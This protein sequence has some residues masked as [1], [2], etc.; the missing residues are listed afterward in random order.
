MGNRGVG[1]GGV[2]GGGA[3]CVVVVAT[4]VWGGLGGSFSEMR[5]HTSY[6]KS[7]SV[8]SM[9]LATANVEESSCTVKRRYERSLLKFAEDK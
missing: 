7:R 6:R 4:G 8:N 1:E 5:L 2:G 3:E 9:S